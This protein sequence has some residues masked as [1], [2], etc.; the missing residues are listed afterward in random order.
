MFGNNKYV[1]M[2]SLRFVQFSLGCLIVFELY[3]FFDD[4]FPFMN[5]YFYDGYAVFVAHKRKI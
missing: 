4:F 3:V 5:V 1:Y 2:W